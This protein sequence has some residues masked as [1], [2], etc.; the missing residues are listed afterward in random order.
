[1]DISSFNICLMLFLVTLTTCFGPYTGPSSGHKIYNWGDYTVWMQNSVYHTIYVPT[2]QRHLVF[3]FPGK[4]NN[5]ISLNFTYIYHIV[6]FTL[7]QLWFTIFVLTSET[8]WALNREIIKQVTSSWSIFITY[9]D[10]ARSD[11]RKILHHVPTCFRQQCNPQKDKWRCNWE[12]PRWRVWN[13]RS[14]THLR[15]TL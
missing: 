3:Q 8:C 4:L 12:V 5:Q 2:I 13:Y 7:F 14:N 10:D 11:E 6:W 1:M 9:Q 15:N